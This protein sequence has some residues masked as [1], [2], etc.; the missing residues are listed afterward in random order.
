MV[1]VGVAAASFLIVRPATDDL[2]VWDNRIGLTLIAA[3]A[4]LATLRLNGVA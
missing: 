4:V 1:W 2:H 3:L